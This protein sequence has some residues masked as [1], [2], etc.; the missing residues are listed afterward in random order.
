LL[1]D[2]ERLRQNRHVLEVAAERLARSG[3]DGLVLEAA[4]AAAYD[5]CPV[6]AVVVTVW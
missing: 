3:Q 2:R 4:I 1:S 6:T 5:R